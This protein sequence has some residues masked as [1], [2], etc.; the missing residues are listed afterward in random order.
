MNIP[1]LSDLTHKISRD[2]GV[3]LEDLGHTLRYESHFFFYLG[4]TESRTVFS[5]CY[6][7]DR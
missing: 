4:W 1:L 6:V 7:L 2:Y 3:L 5:L